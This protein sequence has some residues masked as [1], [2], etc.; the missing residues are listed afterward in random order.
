MTTHE[1]DALVLGAGPGGYVAAI[2]LGQLGVR[3]LI[4]EKEAFGGVCLN[5]GC[6]PSKALIT[7]AKLV[8]RMRGAEAMGIRAS[9]VTVDLAKLQAWKGGVVRR[10]TGGV[11][12]LLK[13]NKVKTLRGE[14]RFVAPNRVEVKTPDGIDVVE[15]KQVIIATGSRPV[16]IPGFAFDGRSILSSTG[17]LALERVPRRLLVIGG[18]YIGLELGIM[19]SKLGSELTVVEMMDQLLPGMD[20]EMV[21][22][23]HRG[24]KKKKV[25]VHLE[26]KALEWKKAKDGLEVKVQT[27][28][29]TLTIETDV[30]L[31]TVGRR[32]N[33]ENLGLETIGVAKDGPFVRVDAEMRT[34]VPGVFAIGDIVGNPMLAHKASKEGEVAAEVIAGKAAA[35]DAR[36]IPAVVFTDPEIAVVGLMEAQA[37][38]KG[39]DVQVGKFPF[40]AIGRALTTGE[41][42]G[43]VKTIVD[44]KSKDLLGVGIVGPE[45]SELV[46]EAALALE[47]GASVEDLALTIHAHPTLA[48]AMMES[49][50]AAL[51]EAIHAVNP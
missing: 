20:P 23:V 49:A 35:F 50:K 29:G 16:E 14:A 45:A 41:T 30:I 28:K 4:V 11:E 37:R 26:S 25:T 39:R 5:V 8:E 22:V 24:L 48:E 19:Y 31:V 33:T 46:A 15:A 36:A 34:S 6:I 7:A 40:T 17:A 10:L 42:E 44:A 18:G 13:E 38:E 43:F 1:T 12:Y 27:G 51:G 9:D 32:P 21:K 47:M 2:R 3:T